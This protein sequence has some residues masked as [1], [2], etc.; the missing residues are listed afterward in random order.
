MGKL[1]YM[2]NQG[3]EIVVPL[4]PDAP[5]VSLGRATDCTIRSNR[6]SVSRRHAEFRYA[7]GIYEVIDLKSSNGTYLIVDDNRQ[8]VS[9][10]VSLKNEDEVWCGDFILHFEDEEV[11]EEIALEA[12]EEDSNPTQYDGVQVGFGA[13]P[14]SY[15]H[16]RAHE[17]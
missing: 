10:R 17:T 11:Y 15:T 9:P 6:K 13:E 1:I 14:V 8:P 4:G 3:R 12:L 16:L 2:D 5:V 7:N